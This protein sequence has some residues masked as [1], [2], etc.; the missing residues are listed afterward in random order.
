M[1]SNTN[2]LE[3]FNKIN[4]PDEYGIHKYR[5]K[6]RNLIEHQKL[7]FDYILMKYERE[8][9]F[10]YIIK[11]AESDQTEFKQ[12]EILNVNILSELVKKSKEFKVIGAKGRYIIVGT[13]NLKSLG[14]P[15]KEILIFSDLKDWKNFLNLN[16]KAIK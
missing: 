14:Y 2:E 7:N 8:F 10:F 9:K 15:D 3:N 13:I 6:W 1:V 4:E 5:F 11:S 16:K 12:I